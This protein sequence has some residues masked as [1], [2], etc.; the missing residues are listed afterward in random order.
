[1]GADFGVRWH[2]TAFARA[3]HVSQIQSAVVPAQSK[4]HP[5]Q[6][7]CRCVGDWFKVVTH[8]Q[9]MNTNNTHALI[10]S[11]IIYAMIIPLAIWMGFMLANPFD[12]GT[13]N[14]AGIFFLILLAPIMLRW[15]HL[16]LIVSWNLG[17]TIFFLPG[18][19]PIWLLMVAL[20]LG[21]SVLHRT[22]NDK[23]KFLSAPSISWPLLFFLTVVLF[24][25]KLTGGIGLNSL[26]GD[27]AGGRSYIMLIFGILGYFA[28]IAQPIPTQKVG[29]YVGLF[30]LSGCAA[31]IGDLVPFVPHQMYFIFALFPTYGSDMGLMEQGN[32]N[33]VARYS[34]TGWMGEALY[35]F[36][37]ARYGPRGIF[38]GGRLWR[39]VIFAV[40]FI[41][42]F[43][44]GFRSLIILGGVIFVIQFF[45][46]R[47]YQTRAFPVFLF[48][49]LIAFTLLIA[50]ASKL[51][52]S[53]Q[54][55]L[56]FV[57]L[58]QIDPRARLD[59][60]ASQ[61]WRLQI[62][63]DALPT[64]PKY[65]LLGKGYAISKSE[66]A[67]ASNQAFQ[68]AGNFE[69]VE[70][71]G[72]YHSGPL[73][74]VIYFGIWGVVAL[75][76]FWIASLRALWFN[77]HYGDPALRTVNIFL[78]SYF[79]ARILLFLVIFGGLYSDMFYFTSVMGLSVS[80]NG[81]I[82]RPVRATARVVDKASD[83]PLARPRFQ[84]FYPR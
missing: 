9:R 29:L 34:G 56:T 1:M 8:R 5:K 67:V 60:E 36:M 28:L 42:M 75:L 32:I 81:G 41:L 27:T 18:S 43:F 76:W 23:V 10:R 71:S 79:I 66:L 48:S 20:S 37:L 82:R 62:W 7:G 61:E 11:L 17:M 57:P 54:R 83:V 2:D 15:H 24:T 6:S 53:V 77:Y 55:S 35:F 63:K 58:L 59:A 80:L 31:F 84:P 45:L 69:Q 14:Y 25:A 13:F 70:I 16:L 46:E 65:L 22:I 3:R 49:G 38:L 68:Y 21:L 47:M 12:R 52:F 26:G 40:S 72:N 44:G 30:F 50:F 19:P 73:S 51:P 39:P 64:V 4:A 33:Y 78:L 74:V